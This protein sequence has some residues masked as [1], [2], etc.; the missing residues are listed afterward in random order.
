MTLFASA[1][2]Q[3]VAFGDDGKV[4]TKTL[5]QHSVST[6]KPR[7]VRL[8]HWLRVLI[9]SI[10]KCG[11]EER[12]FLTARL[13]KSILRD[14]ITPRAYL[15][16]P[17]PRG[18]CRYY[19]HQSCKYQTVISPASISPDGYASLDG[20]L[21]HGMR[22]GVGLARRRVRTLRS[23]QPKVGYRTATSGNGTERYCS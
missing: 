11:E 10:S 17:S 7:G 6:T 4:R 20:I 15:A 21:Q 12:I 16:E 8:Q 14:K 3:G 1:E 22:C 2:T 19:R 9:W 23:T 13:A 5:C 18:F